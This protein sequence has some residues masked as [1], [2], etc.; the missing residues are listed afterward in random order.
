MCLANDEDDDDELF[1]VP[2]YL[3]CSY[4]LEGDKVTEKRR[5]ILALYV[6]ALD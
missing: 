5:R 1:N 2:I 6:S 4:C 3:S